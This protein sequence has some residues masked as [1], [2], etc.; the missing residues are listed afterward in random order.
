MQF[1]RVP[2]LQNIPNVRMSFIEFSK[3][4]I[5]ESQVPGIRIIFGFNPVCLL[6][7]RNGSA[8]RLL[9]FGRTRKG[10]R[11]DNRDRPCAA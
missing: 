6:Q 9:R 1:S 11:A 5:G 4:E 7:G 8:E 3:L 2:C 10:D